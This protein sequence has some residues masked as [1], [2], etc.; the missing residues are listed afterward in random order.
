MSQTEW[1]LEELKRGRSVSPI[2][3]LAGCQCFRLAARVQELRERG[4]NIVTVMVERNGKKYA[5]YRL[6]RS[7]A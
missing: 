7:K 4:N 6:I 1:I 3:A 5:T 2:D